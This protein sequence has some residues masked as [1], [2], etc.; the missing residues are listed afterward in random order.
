MPII[1]IE[2]VCASE[3]EF[4]AVSVAAIADAVGD[5]LGC[6]PGRAWVRLRY[7]GSDCYA[8]NHAELASAELPVFAT[9]LLATTPTEEELRSQVLA[10][11]RTIADTVSRPADRVH[12][13]Y[14]PAGTGRQAFGGRLVQPGVRSMSTVG[15]HR[16]VR[17]LDPADAAAFQALRLAGLQECPSAFASSFAEEAGLPL[18]QVAERLAR[19]E[20]S[21]VFGAWDGDRLAG[22]LGI[23]RESMLK[24]AH[25]ANLWGMYVASSARR[26]GVGRALVDHALAYAGTELRVRQV[27]LGVNAANAAAVRLYEALGFRQFGRE[28][29]FMLLDGRPHDEIHMVRV[30]RSEERVEAP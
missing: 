11:T 19:R 10:L 26:S 3:A 17:L 29:G 6:D 8:E 14:A 13:Q 15:P 27:N 30:L 1:D 7:L 18:E 22:I 24:L 9:V 2:L 12:V 16:S 21:A 28:P 25:K 5:V 4:R 23:H 20:G